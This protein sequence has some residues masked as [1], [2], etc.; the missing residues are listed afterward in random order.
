MAFFRYAAGNQ[1]EIRRGEP[2]GRPPTGYSGYDDPEPYDRHSVPYGLGQGPS[3]QGHAHS[4]R[5]P[6]VPRMPDEPP[7][8]REDKRRRLDDDPY[9]EPIYSS[10][11]RPS[12]YSG[13]FD[14][15]GRGLRDERE[16]WHDSDSD[17]DRY[18]RRG[19]G[20]SRRGS[21]QRRSRQT[22]SR[23]VSRRRDTARQGGER[24]RN[25][26]VRLSGVPREYTHEILVEMHKELGLSTTAFET[27]KVQETSPEDN[28][29]VCTMILRYANEEHARQAAVTLDKQP[30]ETENGRERTLS[31]RMQPSSGPTEIHISVYI[32]DIPVKWDPDGVKQKHEELGLEG[33][34]VPLAVKIL[35]SQDPTQETTACIAR[36]QDKDGAQ[37]AIDLLKGLPVYTDTGTKRHLGARMAKPARWM[38]ATGVEGEQMDAY[39]QGKRHKSVQ[40]LSG[41][42]RG[43]ESRLETDVILSGKVRGWN[44]ERCHGFIHHEDCAIDVF[45][46]QSVLV[47]GS[48]LEHGTPVEFEA[49]WNEQRKRYQA[50]SVTGARGP[51]PPPG[52]VR[53]PAGV[54]GQ[55][56]ESEE[57]REIE[58]FA[59]RWKVDNGT[60]ALIYTLRPGVRRRLLEEFRIP[61]G[62][63]PD[64]VN[65]L[66]V[67]FVRK[68]EF[69]M[70]ANTPVRTGEMLLGLV[71][72][73]YEDRGYGFVA[74]GGYGSP[75]FVHRSALVDGR[76]LVSGCPAQVEVVWNG[77]KRRHE[78]PKCRGAFPGPP[79]THLADMGSSLSADNVCG[80]D[81]FSNKDPKLD[82]EAAVFCDHW[83]IGEEG[84]EWLATF[85]SPVRSRV[86]AE[87]DPLSDSG[88]ILPT[89]QILSKLK[90]FTRIV[91]KTMIDG[92]ELTPEGN[93]LPVG[94]SKYGVEEQLQPSQEALP[95][96]G[97]FAKLWELEQDTVDWLAS[98]PTDVQAA[99]TEEYTGEK[100]GSMPVGSRI[101]GEPA[102]GLFVTGLPKE[103]SEA[104]V[105]WLFRHS[106]EVKQIRLLTPD[107]EKPDRP[108]L[109][110]MANE[111]GGKMAVEDLNNTTPAGC[112]Q[113]ISVRFAS[114]RQTDCKE[115]T[116]ELPADVD[117]PGKISSWYPHRNFGFITP[118]V[119]PDVWVH[120]TSFVGISQPLGTIVTFRAEWSKQH[121]QYQATVVHK[122]ADEPRDPVEVLRRD[123]GMAVRAYAR[124]VMERLFGVP[125]PPALP[126]VTAVAVAKQIPTPPGSSL[127][128]ASLRSILVPLKVVNSGSDSWKKL[129]DASPPSAPLPEHLLRPKPTSYGEASWDAWEGRQ[130]LISS[131][132]MD[133]TED[134]DQD[135]GVTELDSMFGVACSKE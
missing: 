81:V 59:I 93:E 9:G 113:P 21:L 13:S 63:V 40:G 65:K 105:L 61:D 84:K 112:V 39:L 132:M 118:D 126:A 98:L 116:G 109:V 94:S 14:D 79:G 77:Q 67:A 97:Y 121:K 2:P 86:V 71:K 125:K 131:E 115:K 17:A 66:V 11:P 33:S 30:V 53:T 22:R 72:A 75:I 107:A 7:P 127:K 102:L 108:V 128:P 36:Y 16:S 83:E 54:K 51:L 101:S 34:A 114:R 42:L 18:G 76:C 38:V 20:S 69:S 78:G 73:W 103:V 12:S 68:I 110:R 43:S 129:E 55:T 49:Q 5:K 6:R 80:G 87:F 100:E 27:S 111:A 50:T 1:S 37:R 122:V 52:V 133:P 26:T 46:H 23:E 74:V 135:A 88:E 106:G 99:V 91:Q 29:E 130:K 56:D 64:D 10:R 4:V 85:A 96:L 45:V 25:Y 60:Q 31:A 35:P 92:G 15:G 41:G 8:S 90:V 3:Q 117:L 70:A 57:E 24:T 44:R 32:S 62:E 82:E 95:Q 47:D 58:K 120:H 28:D 124:Q 119:G 19:R 134:M 48:H 104:F 123:T 89:A